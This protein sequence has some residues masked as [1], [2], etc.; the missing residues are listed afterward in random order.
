MAPIPE[1]PTNDLN[2]DQLM[3]MG[4]SYMASRVLAAAAQVDI[5]SHLAAGHRTAT[6]LARVVGP[7]ERGL[8]MLLDALSGLQLLTKDAGEYQLTPSAARYLVRASPDYLGAILEDDS[9]WEA[10]GKLAE[11]VRTGKPLRRVEDQAEAEHFFPKLIRSLHVL[12]REPARRAAQVLGAG[13]SRHGLRVLDV[14]CGS[15]IWGIAVAEA[16]QAAVVTMHDFPGVLDHTRD[17][18]RRHDLA[19]RCTY[20]PGNLKTVDF[21]AD[22]YDVALLGNIVHSEGESA[23]RDLF[24]RLHRALRAQGQLAVIDTIPNDQRNGPPFPLLFALNMLLH[25][26]AGDT[27]TLAEYTAWLTDVGFARVKTADIGSPSP[28]VIGVKN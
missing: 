1:S 8:R 3:Q 26:E 9:L 6:D 14:A 11:T 7:P 10:W 27:Y 18:V 12:N 4:M 23:A 28:L 15:G 13:T 16:D 19:D 21:G 25:T 5:F 20:L 2:P 22:Q 17:Y 24:R